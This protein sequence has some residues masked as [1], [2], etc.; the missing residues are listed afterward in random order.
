MDVKSV[1]VQASVTL[2]TVLKNRES[3]IHQ[4]SKFTSMVSFSTKT[5]FEI[6]TSQSF[7]S[8]GNIVREVSD[9]LCYLVTFW[10][11]WRRRLTI[12]P[13]E[14]RVV[15]FPECR[16]TQWTSW[17]NYFQM[18]FIDFF[19]FDINF[20]RHYLTYSGRL[21]IIFGHVT[22]IYVIVFHSLLFLRNLF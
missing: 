6:M 21:V 14:H 2:V 11:S 18:C 5:N 7:L 17:S 22:C 3:K 9:L 12:S 4:R 19:I 13:I 10:C 1:D 15:V 16:I 20:A 8:K